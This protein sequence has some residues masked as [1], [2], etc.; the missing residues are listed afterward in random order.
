MPRPLPLYVVREISRHGKIVFYFRVDKGPRIRL[1]GIPG[2]KEFKAA[3]AYAL[4]GQKLEYVKT[5]EKP[6]SIR[7][8]VHQ[9]MHSDTWALLSVA[10]RKQRGLFYAQIVEASG[11][12]DY[13]RIQTSDI[14]KAVER[15]ARTPALANNFLKALRALFKW[16]V[17]QGHLDNNPASSV[18]RVKHTSEGFPIWTDHEI[19]LFTQRW[20]I[21]SRE[22]LAFEL[23]LASGL[24]RSDIVRLGKQH[25]ANETVRIKTVKTNTAV[26]LDFSKRLIGL[27]DG[28]EKGDLALIVGKRGLPLTKESF[29]NYFRSACRAAG[30]HKSAHGLRKYSATMAANAGATAHQLMAMF[31]WAT[32]DQAEVY[33][34][35]A[36]RERLGK[37]TSRLVAEHFETEIAPHL[38]IGA[39]KNQ[40]NTTKS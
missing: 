22:R 1:P 13:R 23:I 28:S 3:Y 10:T 19:R 40:K 32:I 36:D 21:G 9:Y 27:I 26:T 33:T 29:G 2:S 20:P 17:K 16:A 15:R 18:E 35:K 14:S 37:A 38:D 11:D 24:R 12:I 6:L 34:K 25:M 8:L 7:W 4:R 30:V 31:G 39:G 5:V